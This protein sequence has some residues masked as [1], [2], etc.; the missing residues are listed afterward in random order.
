ML[1]LDKEEREEWVVVENADSLTAPA[2]AGQGMLKKQSNQLSIGFQGPSGRRVG[3]LEQ[4]TRVGNL[5]EFAQ[6]R[7]S[8]ARACAS[9]DSDNSSSQSGGSRKEAV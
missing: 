8:L 2:V 9:V 3:Q 6:A 7:Q 1:G 5:G 4:F